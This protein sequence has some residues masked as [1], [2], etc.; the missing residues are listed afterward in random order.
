MATKDDDKGEPASTSGRVTF[1]VAC[2]F[3]PNGKD[4]VSCRAGATY[5]AGELPSG[6][7]DFAKEHGMLAD[8]ADEGALIQVPRRRDVTGMLNKAITTDNVPRG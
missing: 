1:A 5:N 4:S 6:M 7:V 3:S 2:A 8:K